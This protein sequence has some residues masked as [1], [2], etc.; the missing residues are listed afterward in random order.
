ML[1]TLVSSCSRAALGL[2]LT[3]SLS[4]CSSFKNNTSS[5][6]SASAARDFP[7]YVLALDERCRRKTGSPEHDSE[8]FRRYFTWLN[9]VCGV[10]I[11]PEHFTIVP[12]DPVGAFTSFG[13]LGPFLS[14]GM[15]FYGHIGIQ[16]GSAGLASIA[17]EVGHGTDQHLHYL[18]YVLSSR[19]RVRM[20]AVAEAFEHYIGLWHLQL[21]IEGESHLLR[22]PI[23]PPE[24]S[25]LDYYLRGDTY[26]CA[27]GV[28]FILRSDF[29]SMGD[30]WRF[31]SMMDEDGVYKRVDGLIDGG[32]I[33][34]TIRKGYEACIA[35]K[36][37]LRK[38][39][40]PLREK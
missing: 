14:G 11:R 33:A 32:H 1:E 40:C 20:E 28:V 16:R 5:G 21:G 15:F 27:R 4:G 37:E 30:V 34:T 24:G 31:L 9:G 18:S 3:A 29:K 10:L 39:R 19:A 7:S 8:A 36:D 23:L 6:P 22:K 2:L 17:H 35:E 38:M 13:P 26:D 25:T 12:D